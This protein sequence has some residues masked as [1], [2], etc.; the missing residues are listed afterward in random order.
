MLRAMRPASLLPTGTSSGPG[1][2]GGEDAA[3]DLREVLKA[4]MNQNSMLKRELADL[5]K[6]IDDSTKEKDFKVEVP[7][8]PT[9]T[10]PPSPPQGPP[11]GTP[12]REG[13]AGKP[14]LA[15][16][17]EFCGGEDECGG[18]DTTL[19]RLSSGWTRTSSGTR[20]VAWG[21]SGWK[22]WDWMFGS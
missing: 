5:K 3:L 13:G 17:P 7:R 2:S 11:P 6:K 15:A 20:V 10:P 16:V 18:R 9:T 12:E 14:R 1:P 8:P 4:V 19:G 21:A 22:S